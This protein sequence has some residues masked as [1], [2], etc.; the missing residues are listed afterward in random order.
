MAWASVAEWREDQAT[1]LWL[2]YTR[3]PSQVPVGLI[4][5]IGLPNPNGLVLASELLSRLP[6][7]WWVSAFLG[8][9]QAA[10]L[11]WLC[12]L[13]AG[14]SRLFLQIVGP[15][16]ASVLLRSCSVE[17]V[18]HWT[19]IPV[20]L[21]FFAG[22]VMYL[23][24]GTAWA[25]PLLTT[26]LVLGPA[27]YLAGA[28]NSICYALVIIVVVISKP[29]RGS[30]RA[31]AVP[32]TISLGIV[33]L[34]VWLTWIPYFR[35]VGPGGL[36]VA[37]GFS[38]LPAAER[39]IAAAESILRFPLWSVARFADFG[40]VPQLPPLQVGK[41]VQSARVYSAYLW[42]IR[43]I[44]LQ[45][46]LS[47][48]L[49]A[50]AAIRAV[51]RRLPIHR[52]VAPAAGLSGAVQALMLLFVM[53]SYAIGPLLGAELWARGE[54]LDEAVQFIPF[55]L[56]LWFGAPLVV[57]LPERLRKT[58]GVLTGGIAIFVS[59][60]SM[61]LGFAIVRNNLIYQGRA[62]IADVPLRD[63]MNAV[64]FIATDWKT[65]SASPQIPVD[66]DIAGRRWA[67]VPRF[68]KHYE[69]WY[70]A[71]YT[72]GRIYDYLLLRQYGLW[73]SQ[74]GIQAREFGNGRYLLTYAF[75]P[76]PAAAGHPVRNYLFGRLRVTVV[77]D[78]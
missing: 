5:S 8:V 75:E 24:R 56:I 22:I 46:V 19:L 37:S 40:T 27:I 78:R 33:A 47:Y 54:R 74:E 3:A 23:R 17:L 4:S 73:N 1:N 34:S 25:L 28:L 70:P 52:L 6:N 7:A 76:P 60:L 59:A 63:K 16:L 43:M 44:M 66:Y 62:L 77:S 26:A 32:L 53:L 72:L 29:P 31:H 48:L 11:V 13:L 21:L 69:K 55:L 41:R 65:R 45:G 51:A 15:L 50:F 36:R 49:I 68:G 30:W 64:K 57:D 58:A 35:E 39:L 61:L 42:S 20:N 10:L 12:W 67:R 18:L 14:P 71:P 38:G 2:G 9:L